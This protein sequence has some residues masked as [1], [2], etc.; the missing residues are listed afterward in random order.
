LLGGRL[1]SRRAGLIA[2]W[3]VATSP[4][5]LFMLNSAVTDVPVAAVWTVAWY[6]LLGPGIGSALGAG[7][8]GGFASLIRPNLAPISGCFVI[9]KLYQWYRARPGERMCHFWMVVALGVG[10]LPGAI[11]LALINTHLYGS[12]LLTGYGA[13]S[14]YFSA[15][16]I[17][18][19]LKNYWVWF[20]DAQSPVAVLGLAALV[21]PI[22]RLW[23]NV[24]N[25]GA[26]MVAALFVIGIWAQYLAFLV[27]DASWYIRFLLPCWPLIMIGLARVLELVL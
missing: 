4:P 5:M 9:W 19:N 3:L 10:F 12:P 7:L 1:G 2:A 16:H 18:P 11:A 20:L 14:G 15:S 26:V 24:P 22:Q 8:A 17:L 27:F 13:A 21:L 25:R 23:T 6:F